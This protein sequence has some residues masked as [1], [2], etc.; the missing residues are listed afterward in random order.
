MPQFVQRDRLEI[1]GA[2]LASGSRGPAEAR[3]EVD[4]GF[5]D[6]AGAGI[7]QERGR[8]EHALLVGPVE[9]ANRGPAVGLERLAAREALR[10]EGH[11][12]P[13]RAHPRGRRAANRVAEGLR[14]D[15]AEVALGH[16]VANRSRAPAHG[17]DA[18]SH[19]HAELEIGMGGR[20][21][22]RHDEQG[23][24][25]AHDRAAPGA[26][27]RAS[28]TARTS[29]AKVSSARTWRAELPRLTV[30]GVA[31]ACT[32]DGTTIGPP[33]RAAVDTR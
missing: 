10:A 8:A 21:A 3:V 11:R 17:H 18:A 24:E 31:T 1:G 22:G 12:Q 32:G 27:H 19:F 7:E 29:A 20:G 5:E 15:A 33:A 16:E 25:H 13:R 4:V 9:E 30:D 2:G 28:L 14:R 26:S 23:H 6:L